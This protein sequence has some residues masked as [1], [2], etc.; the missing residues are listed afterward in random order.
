[1]T[2]TRTPRPGPF[3]VDTRV[4]YLG[5]RLVT[6]ESFNG[7]PPVRLIYHGMEVVVTERTSGRQGS[8]RWVEFGDGERVQDCTVDGV[9]VYLIEGVRRAITVE[10]AADWENLGM[11]RPAPTFRDP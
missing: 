6:K 4:R 10:T 7:A 3:I 9:S 2:A 8:G 11:N 5:H 1:M